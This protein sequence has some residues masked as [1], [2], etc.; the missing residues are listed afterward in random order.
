MEGKS[1]RVA[2]EGGAT[3]RKEYVAP[4]LKVY[5]DVSAVTRTAGMNGKVSDGGG[6]PGMSKTS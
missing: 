4:A 3:A 1:E 6:A 5:G 2:P